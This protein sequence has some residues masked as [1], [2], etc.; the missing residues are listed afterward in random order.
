ML[1][2]IIL[3]AFSR[4]ASASVAGPSDGAETNYSASRPLGEGGLEALYAEFEPGGKYGPSGS[5]P[6]ARNPAEDF[7]SERSSNWS[8]VTARD[9]GEY[10][11]PLERMLA[12]VAAANLSSGGDYTVGFNDK[13]NVVYRFGG[14]ESRRPRTRR[15]P[16]YGDAL[17]QEIARQE[18][19]AAHNRS[20]PSVVAQIGAKAGLAVVTPPADALDRLLGG[21]S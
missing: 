14:K 16:V 3:L 13:G 18:T 7:T 9:T 15:K 6:H 4:D 11:D 5:V 8:G 20:R 17:D 1:I 2:L 10:D 21:E 19:Q 12:A